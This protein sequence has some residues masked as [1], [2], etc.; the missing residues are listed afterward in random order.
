[1][2]CLT[3][4]SRATNYLCTLV[5]GFA[6]SQTSCVGLVSELTRVLEFIPGG[7]HWFDRSIV[8]VY[9][10]GGSV[11]TASSSFRSFFNERLLGL[12][13]LANQGTLGRVARLLKEVWGHGD[14]L[15]VG[16][17]HNVSW[18]NVMQMNDWDFLLF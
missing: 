11:S 18:R 17:A 10:I 3:C 6:P 12:G 14:S 4:S 16:E 1:M 5:P 13:S 15:S 9:F 8:W 7:E 2:P